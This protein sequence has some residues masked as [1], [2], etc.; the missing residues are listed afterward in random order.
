[1]T[2]NEDGAQHVAAQVLYALQHIELVIPPQADSYW[3]GEAGPGPSYLDEGSGGPENAWTA[4]NTVFM[5]WN[6]LA[7]VRRSAAER[8]SC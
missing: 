7:K 2:G 4:R 5:K 8:G 1:M 6:M 3:T